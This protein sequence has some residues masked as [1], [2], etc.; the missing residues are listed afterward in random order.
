MITYFVN[1][2]LGMEK[3]MTM[4]IRALGMGGAEWHLHLRSRPPNLWPT[5]G[6]L[7]SCD[8][9]DDEDAKDSNALSDDNLLWET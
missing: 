4:M 8:S 7:F 9:S 2:S 3:M 1:L 6:K 5:T